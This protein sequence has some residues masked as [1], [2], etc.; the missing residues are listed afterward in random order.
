[1]ANAASINSIAI[2]LQQLLRT[3]N[4]RLLSAIASPGAVKPHEIATSPK[5]Q[6]LENWGR[7]ID[8]YL[9]RLQQIEGH[10]DLRA[11]RIRGVPR[12]DRFRENQSIG[13][14]RDALNQ[15]LSLALEAKS[16]L[17]DLFMRTILPGDIQATNMIFDQVDDAIKEFKELSEAI[18]KAKLAKK[19]SQSEAVTMKSV[20]SKDFAVV[21]NPA[22]QMPIADPLLTLSLVARLLALYLR[23][24]SK[25]N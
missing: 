6:E 5:V 18:D 10:L 17:K 15:A 16:R 22:T 4:T 14:K 1:M 23:S 13:D 11:S 21:Q 2:Q 20:M 7:Q 8:L 24:R 25:D 9:K 19:L 12:T 3:I